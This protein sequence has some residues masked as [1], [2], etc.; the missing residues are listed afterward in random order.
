MDEDVKNIL[1][2]KTT[3]RRAVTTSVVSA[4]LA[5]G[6]VLT[7]TSQQ[8][9]L[10]GAGATF[11]EPLYQRYSSELRKA[12][13]PVQV[14]YQGIG[15]GGGVR[16]FIAG[17][18]DFGAS[19]NAM[20]DAEVQK[21][22]RGVVFVPTAGGPVAVVYNQPGVNNL[23]LSRQTLPR[24]FSGQITNWND[25]AIAKDNPGVNLPNQPIRLAVRADS[26]GTTFIF[27][28]ALSQMEAYFKGR[29]GPNR[30]PKWPGKPLS[31]KG[32]PGVAQIVQRTKG[33]IGYVES[34]FAEQNK[35][36]TAL[37]QNRKGE[38]VPPTLAQA[39]QALEN[40][41]FNPDFRV[42]YSGLG[43]PPD[44]YPITGLTW[45]MVYR[46]YPQPGK[47]AAVKR[48]VQWMMN[49]GQKLNENVGYTRIPP[50]VTNRVVQTVNQNVQGK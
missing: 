15:S 16:Q 7:A 50:N 3:L 21:V 36:Q 1:F 19:D 48:M 22:Q 9:T 27:T 39:N 26:S 13:P 34:T 47:A 20:T 2:T 24:I 31:G 23:K 18:V 35:L 29:I 6:P 25:P 40:V 38:F 4:T 32:N 11:P 37:V 5:L 30:A 42:D 46:N 28:N 43:N 8:A 10:N 44:G 45:I 33:S 17:S 41:K 12:N 49:E 14:N